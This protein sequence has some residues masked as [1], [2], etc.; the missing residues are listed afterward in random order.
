MKRILK[1]I[2]VAALAVGA[3]VSV[4]NA[5]NLWTNIIAGLAAQKWVAFYPD[6]TFSLGGTQVKDQNCQVK[7]EVNQSG[8]NIIV[9]TCFASPNPSTG[10]WGSIFRMNGL[11]FGGFEIGSEGERIGSNIMRQAWYLW[12]F[13]AQRTILYYDSLT[14]VF[15]VHG[16][17][18]V[19]GWFDAP[20]GGHL[21]T[22]MVGPPGGWKR[23]YTGPGVCGQSTIVATTHLEGVCV[24][25]N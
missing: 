9:I 25:V 22:F 18:W 19:E 15:S 2:L 3:L 6:P 17:L 1:Y 4:T 7:N 14:R 21:G 8:A 13:L 11:G 12:D 23:G 24:P 16:G 5:Q 10:G 20:A